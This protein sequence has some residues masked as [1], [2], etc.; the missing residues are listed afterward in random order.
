M[1]W[2]FNNTDGLTTYSARIMKGDMERF[3]FP[4][5]RTCILP[6]GIS[7]YEGPMHDLRDKLGIMPDEKVVGVIGRLKPDR[8]FDTIL[9][10]FK[11]LLQRMDKVKLVIVGRSSQI[12]K[13]VIQPIAKLGIGEN[14]ILAGYRTEDYFDMIFTFDLFVMMRAGS[15]G[16]ARALREVMAMGTPAIVSDRGMLPE[17]VEEG[18]SG[19]VVPSDENKLAEKLEMLLADDEKRKAFGMLARKTAE[20]KWNYGI[21]A[22]KMKHYYETLLGLGRRG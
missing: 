1:T 6:P 16:S 18:R 12:E 11:I 5:N 15:D 8:G 2:A 7:L 14:V 10:A 4:M 13:S 22:E 17:L 9:K 3:R 19:Y 20:E 21:Q